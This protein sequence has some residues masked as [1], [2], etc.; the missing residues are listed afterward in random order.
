MIIKVTTDKER[1]KSMIKLILDRE[2][3]ISKIDI[4]EFSTIAT[5][6]YYEIIKEL[7]TV[8]L[9]LEGLKAT[10]EGAHKELINY[11]NTFKEFSEY[12]INLLDDLRIKRNKSSYEG[13]QV[14]KSYL[15]NKKEKILNIIN[16]QKRIIDKKLNR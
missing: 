8:L 10:G 9:L 7:S 16:K 1:V 5:E 2:R 3:F 11:L 15:E 6:N 12:E 4:N 13:K 14:D